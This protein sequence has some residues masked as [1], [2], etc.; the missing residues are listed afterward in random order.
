[1]QLVLRALPA[2]G[3]GL[4]LLLPLGCGSADDEGDLQDQDF[5]EAVIDPGDLTISVEDGAALTATLR[6]GLEGTPGELRDTVLSRVQRTNELVRDLFERMRHT[7]D[8][9]EPSVKLPAL[10]GWGPVLREGVQYRFW[11]R[12]LGAVR[13]RYHLQARPE[14]DGAYKS[15]LWGVLHRRAPHKGAGRMFLHFDN[16]RQVEPDYPNQGTAWLL[17]NNLGPRR[18]HTLLMRK[19]AHGDEDP[20]SA[21]YQFGRGDALSGFRFLAHADV[22]GGPARELLAVRAGWNRHGDGRGDGAVWSGDVAPEDAPRV[23]H[24]CW[25]DRERVYV[26]F[27]PDHPEVADVGTPEAC[28]QLLAEAFATPEADEAAAATADTDDPTFTIDDLPAEE[29]V[30]EEPPADD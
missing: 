28:P 8:E 11:V 14:G 26:D 2:L 7:V 15:V 20:L 29:D 21:A 13:F 4:T 25:M 1:M 19:V 16:M 6:Q 27:E 12:R 17:F 24:E 30:S 3:L 23:V 18:G 9:V 5:L 22:I 10:R